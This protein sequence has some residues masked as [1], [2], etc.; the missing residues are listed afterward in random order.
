M[1][2]AT[3]LLEQ[4]IDEDVDWL[5]ANEERHVGV[6]EK[7]IVAGEPVDAIYIL[8]EG[9]LG[10]V[11]SDEAQ[12]F[13]IVGPG[14]IVGEMSFVERV[15]PASTVAAL[16]SSTLLVVAHDVLRRRADEDPAFAARLFRGLALLLSHRLRRA[17][18]DLAARGDATFDDERE[19]ATWE[20]VTA[21]VEQ[22]K[23]TLVGA[24]QAAIKNGGEVPAEVAADVAALVE[25]LYHAME[26]AIGDAAP[27]NEQFKEQVGIR[28]KTELLPY[29]LLTKNCARTYT[30][31]RGY[32]GDYLTIE[33]MYAAQP[34]G[35]PPL[36]PLLDACMF[37]LPASLAVRN[38]RALLA[39][40]IIRVVD[41]RE[42]E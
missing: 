29:V 6:G 28:I 5:L 13:D 15:T 34:G 33:W 25:G 22:I 42:G 16:E 41:A 32:A 10:V 11:G 19:R 17:R 12:P 37:E 9:V 39:E 31:P 1:S 21:G 3:T 14:D 18:S 8:L 2:T 27:G 7:V 40:E 23:D 30:K 4:L 38:R 36:G 26:A 20:Q 24:S 35:V